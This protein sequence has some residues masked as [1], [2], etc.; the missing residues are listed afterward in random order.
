MPPGWRRNDTGGGDEESPSPIAKVNECMLRD[1]ICGLGKCLDKDVGYACSCHPGAEQAERD[2]NPVCIDVDECALDYCRGGRCTNTP[3]SFECRCPPGFDPVDGGRRCSDK[4]E[5][6]LT[7][8]G[9]CANGRCVP[10]GDG[11]ECSCD[12]GY[13]PTESGGACSDVDECRDNQRV[14]RRGRCHNTPGSY[15][16]RCEPGFAS[17]AA[18]Y[19]ADIDECEDTDACQGGRCVNSEGSFSCVCEAGYRPSRDRGACQDVDECS[20]QSVCRNGRCRNTPGSFRC[21]CPA[22]FTLSADGRSCL[23]EVRDL[24]YESRTDERCEGA[25]SS[26][27]TRSQCCCGAG[28]NGRGWGVGCKACPERGSDELARLCP[29]EEGRDNSG[30]DINECT[31]IPGVCAHGACENL[32]PGYRCICDPGYHQHEDGSCRDVDECDMHESVSDGM[33]LLFF[34]THNLIFQSVFIF[35]PNALK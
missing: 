25:G 29:E 16:C 18:G 10:D 15:E 3:G 21:D 31:M 2:G 26:P 32:D 13:E 9:K 28:P 33:E 34:I 7:E 35:V 30:A 22:D 23:D 12:A 14:C 1:N 8:G 4:N 6:E 24:C 20:E 5:C 17:S 27:V 19:C 11:Y